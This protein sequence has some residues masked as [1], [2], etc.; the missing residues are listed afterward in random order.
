[1]IHYPIPPYL[2]PAYANM[3]MRNF[4]ISEVIHREVL[5]LPMFPQLAKP[6]TEQVISNILQFYIK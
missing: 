5:S 3:K 2:Q 1:M 6:E 4:P